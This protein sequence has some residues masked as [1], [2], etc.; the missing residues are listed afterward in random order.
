MIVNCGEIRIS[1]G[2]IEL[3]IVRN[4]MECLV[5]SYSCT[6]ATPMILYLP[7]PY[8]CS[9]R[10]S[11]SLRLYRARRSRNRNIIQH[12]VDPTRCRH[13]NESSSNII[14]HGWISCKLFH[15]GRSRTSM[16]IDYQRNR[17]ARGDIK[18]NKRM[19]NGFLIPTSCVAIFH[20]DS[21]RSD[22]NSNEK[23]HTERSERQN[24]SALIG[25]PDWDTISII[26][27]TDKHLARPAYAEDRG[28]NN[29]ALCSQLT[30][31]LLAT[32]SC[33]VK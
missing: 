10:V 27:A 7:L 12:C 9:S 33:S 11:V 26:N 25:S 31:L 15:S 13:G 17:H 8:E 18:E 2:T 23:K 4:G 14:S 30:V 28:S 6:V 29:R 3:S 5:Y 24:R 19:D 32:N 1:L 22:E 16:K 21:W 20:R